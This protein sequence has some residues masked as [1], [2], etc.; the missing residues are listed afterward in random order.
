MATKDIT[1]RQVVEAYR[2][3]ERGVDPWPYELLAAKTREPEKV[4]YRACERA[5]RRGLLEYGTS[6]RSGWI[7]EAGR[8]LLAGSE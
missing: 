7:T 3:R 6:L 2:D 1:D 5:E 4:C 8:D